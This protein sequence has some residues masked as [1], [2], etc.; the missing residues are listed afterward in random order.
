MRRI[1]HFVP[2]TPIPN[3]VT[4]TTFVT[5]DEKGQYYTQWDRKIPRRRLSTLVAA[6][7][8]K[9]VK[10][11]LRVEVDQTARAIIYPTGNVMVKTDSTQYFIGEVDRPPCGRKVRLTHATNRGNPAD[12]FEVL[13]ADV[14]HVTWFQDGHTEVGYRSAAAGDGFEEVACVVESAAKV[15]ATL[16]GRDK[17]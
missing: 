17:A 16:E 14:N 11:G 8:F 1:S 12:T 10:R 2:R 4:L 6:G 5:V 15:I 13:V 3:Q 7:M 9:S